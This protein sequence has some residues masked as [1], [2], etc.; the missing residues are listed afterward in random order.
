MFDMGFRPN[1]TSGNPGRGH[2]FYTGTPVYPFGWGLSYSTFEYAWASGGEPGVGPNGGGQVSVRADAVSRVDGWVAEDQGNGVGELAENPLPA[3]ARVA[4]QVTNAGP[5]RSAVVVLCLVHP[6]EGTQEAVG[7]PQQALV[8]FNRSRELDPGES[9]AFEFGAP[10]MQGRAA[11]GSRFASFWCCSALGSVVQL[12]RALTAPA[13]CPPLPRPCRAHCEGFLGG[14][15]QRDGGAAGGGVEH[16][17]A[18]FPESFSLSPTL[19]ASCLEPRWPQERQ[20]RRRNTN[21]FCA[22]R[23][24]S[25]R[26]LGMGRSWRRWT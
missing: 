20:R 17:G 14:A 6:P 25:R 26:R 10:E 2:R 3:L 18:F 4:F 21:A 5:R 24:L 11:A 23:P 7:A 9:Q 16:N 8:W 1:A 22:R 13:A 15:A 19:L 12:Q